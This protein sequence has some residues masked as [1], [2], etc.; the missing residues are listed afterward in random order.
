M[1]DVGNTKLEEIIPGLPKEWKEGYVKGA[2]ERF[3]KVAAGK[4]KS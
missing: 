2:N 3:D 4:Y 1:L